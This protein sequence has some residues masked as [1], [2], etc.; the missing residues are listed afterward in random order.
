MG[1]H[2]HKVLVRVRKRKDIPA[3]WRRSST[4]YTQ[5][6]Y[7]LRVIYILYIYNLFIKLQP[8]DNLR[9]EKTVN[10]L[11]SSTLAASLYESPLAADVLAFKPVMTFDDFEM[12]G[13][14]LGP[15]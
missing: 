2:K 5:Y 11:S 6:N 15:C 12:V 7:A 8:V 14:R 4:H 1:V 3:H 9:C 13:V 10:I